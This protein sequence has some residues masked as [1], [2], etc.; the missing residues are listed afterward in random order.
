M[1]PTCCQQPGFYK[2]HELLYSSQEA[3][4]RLPTRKCDKLPA[5]RCQILQML[6]NQA[7]IEPPLGS[8][9]MLPT[10]KCDELPAYRCQILQ[11]LINHTSI[12]PPLDRCSSRLDSYS[13]LC[14]NIMSLV[15]LAFL[16]QPSGLLL[17]LLHNLSA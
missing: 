10:R 5:Y 2:L 15:P 8:H 12:E 11:T 14:S 1:P 9:A 17:M 7:S 13:L 6:I 4:A 16:V 3:H